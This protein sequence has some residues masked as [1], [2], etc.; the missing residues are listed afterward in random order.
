MFGFN[1]YIKVDAALPVQ[2][3]HTVERNSRGLPTAKFG[4]YAET[5]DVHAAETDHVQAFSIANE[6]GSKQ[7]R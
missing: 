6:S 5:R 3:R 4:A 1:G 7:S 2:P